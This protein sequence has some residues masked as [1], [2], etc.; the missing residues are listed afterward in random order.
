[1]DELESKI[2]ELSAVFAHAVA[3][4]VMESLAQ[5]VPRIDWPA[6][7]PRPTRSVPTPA[8]AR[9]L[10]AH[11]AR[12][13]PVWSAPHVPTV[14]P[15]AT[16]PTRAPAPK[17]APRAPG[18]VL[19]ASL[20]SAATLERLAAIVKVLANGPLYSEDLRRELN[21]TRRD[22]TRAL[23]EGIASGKVVK[24]GERRKTIYQ[25]A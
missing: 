16:A 21:L 8:P 19:R 2:T 18:P 3:R 1:M 12:N 11:G 10:A 7:P 24:T 4:A 9:P 25:V 15:R 20:P 14:G 13:A 23:V 17:A 6:A 5:A 22:L